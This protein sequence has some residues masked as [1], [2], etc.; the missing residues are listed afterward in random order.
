[1]QKISYARYRFPPVLIQNAVWLYFRFPLS[2]RDVEGM[3]VE[4]GIDVS[5]ETVRRWALKFGP[6]YAR[7]L[8]KTLLRLLSGGWSVLHR[9]RQSDS[10]AAAQSFSDNAPATA[11]LSI[12]TL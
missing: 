2:F 1:M 3:L 5:Y 8:R 6:V 9:F 7:K 4:R 11:L 12:D 10:V